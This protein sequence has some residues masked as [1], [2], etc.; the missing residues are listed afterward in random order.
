MQLP[1]EVLE[2]RIT[3][4]DKQNIVDHTAI[5]R[6]LDMLCDK[7]DDL[8]NAFPTRKEYEVKYKVNSDRITAVENILKGV[9]MTVILAILG[10][11]L[12]LV[13]IG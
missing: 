13:I 7:F 9:G 4:M 6:K 10:S 1:M 12:K 5:M 2:E 3:N 8:P 11:L